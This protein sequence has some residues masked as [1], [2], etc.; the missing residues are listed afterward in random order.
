VK[1]TEIMSQP[2]IT[3]TPETR[4]KEV[5]RL[6]VEHGISAVPVVDLKGGLVGIVSEADLISL[7]ARP[8]PRTQAMPLP[9][10]A[11]STPRAVSEVMTRLVH[12]VPMDAEVSRAARM[13][14]ETDVKRVPVMRGR[15]VV[16]IVS[17]RDLL[18]VI[19]RRDE[20][21][22]EEVRRRLSDAGISGSGEAV[23]VASGVVTIGLD[24][25]ETAG[26]LAES[27]ALTV[28]GVLEVRLTSAPAPSSRQR[29]LDLLAGEPDPFTG[30]SNV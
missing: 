30:S 2:V 21:V 18:K 28:P 9:P 12:T 24:N 7:D 4:I 14:L 29:R 10:T 26:R 8:D 3:V 1:V 15:Q 19:A 11:G 16:G 23:D 5:A 22:E 27:V 6:L 25:Q 20:D 17:R 13:M